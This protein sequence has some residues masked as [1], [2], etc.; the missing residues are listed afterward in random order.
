[1]TYNLTQ[2]IASIN[3]RAA[4]ANTNT[5][6]KDLYNIVVEANQVGGGSKIYDSSGDFPAPDSS[7]VGSILL[8]AG[9]HALY[10]LDSPS[11]NWLVV[12]TYEPTPTPVAASYAFQGTEYGYVVGGFGSL[13]VSNIQQFSFTSEA[14]TTNNYATLPA[15]N[16]DAMTTRSTDYGYTVGGDISPATSVISKF[17]F[18]TGGS[19]TVVGDLIVPVSSGS[20]ASKEEYGYRGAGTSPTP[21]A[22]IS[23]EKFSHVTDGN[24]VSIG[25]LT[26]AR[27]STGQGNSSYIAGYF[28]SGGPSSYG[29]LIEKFP[30]ASDTTLTLPGSLTVIRVKPASQSS[31]DY[32]YNSGGSPN[33][34]V[35]DKFQ[36]AVDG[37]AVDIGDLTYASEFVNKGQSS[38]TNGYNSGGWPGGSVTT[39]N[40][41]SFA[42]NGN[43]VLY[44]GSLST[45][46]SN[47]GGI[48][49]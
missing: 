24:S 14:N 39:M 31:T 35:I 16:T 22:D 10:C 20:T 18:A 6:I 49:N 15:N 48:Q 2:I 26:Y 4:A 3:A 23:Y 38:T 32:G 40:K 29:T 30:F 28:T 46:T 34:N 17:P 21:G 1:M 13:R 7:Y 36:F 5:S 11:G 42:S 19:S 44:G 27:Y 25:N 41:F 12:H 45:G 9:D 37:D 47:S 33:V 8:S 43:A